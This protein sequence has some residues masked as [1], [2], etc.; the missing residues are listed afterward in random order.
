VFI[1]QGAVVVVLMQL[2]EPLADKV[3][4]VP[5]LMGQVEETVPQTQVA[6]AVVEITEVVKT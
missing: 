5:G 3:A 1:T 2:T 6:V 4:V